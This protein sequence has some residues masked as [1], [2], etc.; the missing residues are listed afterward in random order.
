MEMLS[1]CSRAAGW[2]LV[3]DKR[4]NQA[5]VAVDILLRAVRGKQWDATAV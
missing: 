2:R 5:H 1:G 4:L 3:V